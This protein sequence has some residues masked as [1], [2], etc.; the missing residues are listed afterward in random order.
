MQ[1]FRNDEHTARSGIR[2]SSVTIIR[3]VNLLHKKM[4]KLSIPLQQ[5]FHMRH[6][7]IIWITRW[8]IHA[9]HTIDHC[10]FVRGLAALK[11]HF[12]VVAR[13]RE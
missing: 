2:I 6:T 10:T 9:E 4:L 5:L 1:I 3:I 8:H 13:E 12:T 7:I 11:N